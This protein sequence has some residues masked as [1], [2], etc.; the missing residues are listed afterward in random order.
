MER[1]ARRK[2]GNNAKIMPEMTV[3]WDRVESRG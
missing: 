3:R 1:K 2:T